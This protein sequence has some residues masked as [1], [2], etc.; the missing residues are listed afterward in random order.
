MAEQPPEIAGDRDRVFNAETCRALRRG[1]RTPQAVF[2]MTVL[3]A[4]ALW[5]I[6]A[7]FSLSPSP[8]LLNLLGIAYFVA[9]IGTA[10]WA[11]MPT[12]EARRVVKHTVVW[13]IAR[14][15]GHEHKLPP[16]Y[17]PAA[18]S[19]DHDPEPPAVPALAA[20]R[21]PLDWVVLIGFPA[22]VAFRLILVDGV[23]LGVALGGCIVLGAILVRFTRE[24]LMRPTYPP[25]DPP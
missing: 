6:G 23:A 19:E 12:R 9:V 16:E 24:G 8:P 11:A 15:F 10:L 17:H 1:S 21:A 13:S 2:V 18:D 5:A 14:I 4:I 22:A 7:L 3:G 20:G 25:E